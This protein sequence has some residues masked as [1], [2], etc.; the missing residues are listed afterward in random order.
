M[1]ASFNE[2]SWMPWQQGAR[3]LLFDQFG[4]IVRGRQSTI[5]SAPQINAKPDLAQKLS[6]GAFHW[7]IVQSL[8]V[9]L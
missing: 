1:K 9:G 2:A 3:S 7:S 5:I 4:C 8:A 6:E